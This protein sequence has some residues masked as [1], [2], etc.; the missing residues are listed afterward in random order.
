MRSTK[1]AGTRGDGKTP[2]LKSLLSALYGLYTGARAE[3][4]DQT[5]GKRTGAEQKDGKHGLYCILCPLCATFSGCRG[6]FE[7]FLMPGAPKSRVALPSAHLNCGLHVAPEEGNVRHPSIHLR[8]TLAFAPIG[9][10][11][12]SDYQSIGTFSFC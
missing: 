10:G 2:H 7:R 3:R 5:V 8:L 6:C 11:A 4:I 1:Q 12:I 9:H